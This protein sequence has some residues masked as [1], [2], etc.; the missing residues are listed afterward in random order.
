MKI[1]YFKEPSLQDDYVDVHYRKENDA[2]E[3][4]RNFFFR[5]R[6]L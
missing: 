3:V 4:I 6:A 5:F 2:V 1:H